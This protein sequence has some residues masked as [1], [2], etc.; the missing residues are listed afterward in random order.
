MVKSLVSNMYQ[1]GGASTDPALPKLLNLFEE[2]SLPQSI[3]DKGS[4][5]AGTVIT[6]RRFRNGVLFTEA[7]GQELGSVKSSDLCAALFD[8]YLGNN[9]VS[10]PAQTLA[11]ET[12]LAFM[13]EAWRKQNRPTISSSQ[14][15]GGGY[16]KKFQTVN[17]LVA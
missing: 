3:R 1:V 14:R 2:E 11:G 9:P 8:L 13:Q 4:V 16:E 12:V 6:F 17:T 7:E 10:R 5:K 15:W